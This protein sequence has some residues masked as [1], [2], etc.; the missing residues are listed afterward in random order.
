MISINSQGLRNSNR[1]QT[2]FNLIKTRKYDVIFL[3]ET[4]WTDDL[5]D[6]ILREWGGNILFNNFEC[7]ARGTAILFSPHFDFRMCNNTCDPHGRTIQTLIEHADRKFNLIN[8]YAPRTNAERR[9]YFHSIS[10]YIS[11]TDDNVLGGDFNCISDNKL[12]KLGGNPAARQTASTILN[13]ITQ[14]N[15]LTDIWRDR[16]R[17]VKKFTWT[18]KHSQNSFIHTR[19][20]KI[21]ISSQLTPFVTK[22]DILPFSF[23]DHDLISLTFDLNTQPRGEGY[24]LFNNNL[25]DDGIF[26]TEIESFWTNWLTKKNEFN[27][28]LKWWDTAK[29][30]FKNIAVKRSTQL[31][32]HQR[33]EY[34][35]LENKILHLQQR[36]ANGD[37]SISEGY[38]QAKNE[39]QHYHLNQMAAIAART[40]IQYAEEGE[41]STRYFFSLENQQKTK[42]TIKVLT[43]NNLDT[44]TDTHDIITETRAFYKK[45]YMA[46]PTDP[47]KQTEF[48]NITTPT[49]TQQDRN[50]CE[51]HITENELQTALKTMENNKSPGLDGLSTN[52]YKHFWP[53]LGHELTH[54]YNYAFDHGQLPLTQRRG[55]ISLL[56][57]KGDRTQLQNWRPITLLNTDYKIL[58]KALA[59]RLK[60][61]LPLLVHTDQTAC[62]PGRTINDNL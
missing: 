21:Y 42:Q 53:I 16:N 58:T 15:N 5:N 50:P 37:N 48:L 41:K 6:G 17:D 33:H 3:Q 57:K 1:R 55:I 20:D 9:I 40:K 13:T 18:G 44:I 29:T 38:L 62:I 59:N 31:S 36:L 47:Y 4:H 19:I 2:V 32:K 27:T 43:K 51:G 26:T 22:T 60:H 49:L 35:R 24:W 11:N 39:L 23:S 7:N 45:L 10:T 61:T 28:P 52:F 56:F 8:V 14:Q 34:R 12:D 46:Q 30:N 25:L 54:V